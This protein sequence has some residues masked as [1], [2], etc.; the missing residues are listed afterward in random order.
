MLTD[1]LLTANDR[2]RIRQGLLDLMYVAAE[3]QRPLPQ[4]HHERIA[5]AWDAIR[6]RGEP[7]IAIPDRYPAR[8]TVPASI[9]HLPA[10]RV[11]GIPGVSGAR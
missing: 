9:G 1:I 2:V 7:P 3:S 10:V 4:V 11:A 8:L 5:F 6:D